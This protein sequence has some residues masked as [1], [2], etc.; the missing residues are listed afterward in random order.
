MRSEFMDFNIN[1]NLKNLRK[2]RGFSQAEMAHCLGYSTP[3]AYRKIE[4]GEQKITAEQVV[5]LAK[6]LSVPSTYLFKKVTQ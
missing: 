5:V 6:K 4:T 3:A 2:L 1:L